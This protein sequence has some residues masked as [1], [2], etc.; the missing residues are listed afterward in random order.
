MKEKAEAKQVQEETKEV[1]GEL[2]VRER[3]L[4]QYANVPDQPTIY[5][6]LQMN[7]TPF[8]LFAGKSS[9][10]NYLAQLVSYSFESGK[11]SKEGVQQ[12]DYVQVKFQWS[13]YKTS[14]DQVFFIPTT[15][16]PFAKGK[17]ASYT[18]S[19]DLEGALQALI[20]SQTPVVLRLKYKQG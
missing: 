15:D 5:R 1:T 11:L 19:Y 18:G 13:G 6:D 17:L 10:A 8:V 16:F 14:L 20:E 3:M 4:A 2:T 9:P 12:A 7:G